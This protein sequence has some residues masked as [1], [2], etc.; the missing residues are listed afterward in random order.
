MTVKIKLAEGV[1]LPEYKTS[2]A[3]AVDLSAN[4]TTDLIIGPGQT[5]AISTGVFV[6]M[7]EDPTLCALVLP[8]SG[9]GGKGLVLGNTVGLIDN[10]YQG[11]VIIMAHNR[12]P[13]VVK[14]GMGVGS[15]GMHLTIT[16]GMRLAQMMFLNFAPVDLE[17]VEDFEEET[18]RGTGGFGSTGV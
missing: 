11:E 14:Q 13:A 17:V 7:T 12:N 2:G 9:L 8:R 3:A 4:I 10:D 5:V 16:P 18:E 15:S 1:K 6:D